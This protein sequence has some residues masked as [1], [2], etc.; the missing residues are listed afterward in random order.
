MSMLPDPAA[1]HRSSPPVRLPDRRRTDVA[2]TAL[3]TGCRV[4]LRDGNHALV[5]PTNPSRGPVDARAIVTG[6]PARA[7]ATPRLSIVDTRTLFGGGIV[8]ASVTTSM[9]TVRSSLLRCRGALVAPAS[10]SA[11]VV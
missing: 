9:S 10:A 11:T 8:A 2:L 5:E 6:Q 1:T 4:G 7:A 3:P